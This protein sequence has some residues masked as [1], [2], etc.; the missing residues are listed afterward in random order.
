MNTDNLLHLAPETILADSNI[1][2]KLFPWQIDR[3]KE[4]IEAVGE[5]T[6]PVEVEPLPVEHPSGKT[7]RL[8]TGFRR[9]T[10][11]SQLNKAGAGLLLPAI[12]RTPTS[13]LDR[14]KRQ[15]ME[16]M[17]REN[18]NPIDKAIAMQ[19]MLEAG[20]SKMDVRKAFP[21]IGGRKGLKIQEASNSHVNQI[22]S[23]LRLP[24][25][26]QTKVAD[27]TLP[28]H[29]VWEL[30]DKSPD[31][32]EEILQKAEANRLAE[33]DKYE[34]DEEKF[35]KRAAKKEAA[36]VKANE[37]LAKQAEAEK[38]LETI[39]TTLETVAPTVQELD[40]AAKAAVIASLER[41]LTKEQKKIA[42]EHAKAVR[43]EADAAAKAA[44]AAA[45][46]LNAATEKVKSLA[47]KAAE[48]KAKIAAAR[49]KTAT[50]TAAKAVTPT[51]IKKAAAA[52]PDAGGENKVPLSRKDMLEVVD[53]MS[54]PSG[55]P[56]VAKIG[57][58][59]VKCFAGDITPGQLTV[60]LAKIT[61]EKVEKAK[62]TAA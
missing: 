45:A 33:L 61:G 57:E 35:L 4:E 21:V 20:A 17:E 34:A 38:E 62:V 48:N 11:V 59:F 50:P 37:A 43:A 18:L 15:I 8:T 36:T 24:K 12:A 13:A 25:A 53:V 23:L 5:V 22:I 16:N 60:A 39:R 3:M 27:G 41:G 52:T 56:K 1:R 28:L 26:I 51:D 44:D 55:Y 58:A 42:T 47:E 19:R 31:K 7:Y 40:K 6:T 46:K 54:K 2:F 14:V 49:A 10:A 30:M 9:F 32:W 29:S